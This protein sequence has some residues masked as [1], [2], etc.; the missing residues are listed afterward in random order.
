MMG[1]DVQKLTKTFKYG[2]HDVT[3][4]TGRVAR[5]ANGS[6]IVSAGG[7]VALAGDLRPSTGRIMAACARAAVDLGYKPENLG[8]IPSPA[9]AAYGISREVPSMMSRLPWLNHRWYSR[10]IPPRLS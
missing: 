7:T 6:V 9:L 10:Y 1:I 8:R 2:D 3:L 5:Q 4:E